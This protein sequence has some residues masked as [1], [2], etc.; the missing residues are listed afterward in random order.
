MSFKEFIKKRRI[1]KIKRLE[2]FQGVLLWFIE[3]AVDE[4]EREYLETLVDDNIKTI[5]K[6]R[7]KLT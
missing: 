4:E 1:A 3:Y 5:N 2:E 6:L 7:S